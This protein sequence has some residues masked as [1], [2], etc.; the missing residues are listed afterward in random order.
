MN[1]SSSSWRNLSRLAVAGVLALGAVG[2]Y[3]PYKPRMHQRIIG[4]GLVAEYDTTHDR[5]IRFGPRGRYNL[6]WVKD[7]DEPAAPSDE[8]TYYGGMFSWVSPQSA[9]ADAKGNPKPW[10]PPLAMDAGPTLATLHGLNEFEAVGPVLD[11]GLQEIKS[12]QLGR[13]QYGPRA[14][15]TNGLKNTTDQPQWGGIWLSTAAV[16]GSVIAV[17]TPEGDREITLSNH[18]GAQEVWDN[19]TKTRSRWTLIRTKRY[20]GFLGMGGTFKATVPSDRVIAIHRRGYWFVRIGEPWTP[21]SDPTL[22]EAGQGPVEVAVNFARLRHE[23]ALLGP[24]SEIAPGQTSQYRERWYI[25]PGMAS[26]TRQLDEELYKIDPLRFPLPTYLQD[27]EADAELDQWLEDDG[28][29]MAP[30]P[31]GPVE[32]APPQRDA[33]DPPPIDIDDVTDK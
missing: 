23:A 17:I 14:L 13:D 20:Y 32:G 29:P 16:P 18:P 22:T 31:E 1:R 6:L 12:L 28:E 15:V 5:L 4:S 11:S 24:I 30:P 19:I 8:Y 9:W 3:G 7:L 2:C 25:I 26:R 33:H 10:P 27:D 21:E